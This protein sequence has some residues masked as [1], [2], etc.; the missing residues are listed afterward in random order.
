MSQ[1]SNL[2]VLLGSSTLV[3]AL[4]GYVTN[5]IAVRMLFHPYRPV[6]I[7]LFNIRFQGLLPSKKD[8]FADRIGEIAEVYLK[9]SSFKEELEDKMGQA[10]KRALEAEMLKIFS[11]Y[12]II[13][14]LISPYIDRL[15]QMLSEKVVD[16]L[17][18]GITDETIKNIDIKGLV[19]NRIKSLDPE[20]IEDFYKRFAKKE[21]RMIEYAGLFLGALIGPVE[22]LI[23]AF[24][25]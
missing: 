17:S 18:G 4:V 2:V 19:S 12:P 14:S 15:A 7:P 23:L 25:H 5:L 8:E 22:A 16:F 9:T 13:S 10:L 20:E 24:I 1:L 6:K 21:L 3:G 11:S